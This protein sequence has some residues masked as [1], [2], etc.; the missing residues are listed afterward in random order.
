MKKPK[1]VLLI[2]TIV[3]QL[4]ILL[5]CNR[6]KISPTTKP[7]A[8]E[9]NIAWYQLLGGKFEGISEQSPAI[10]RDYKPWTIQQ[11]I[12]DIIV[13]DTKAFLGINGYGIA[14]VS[15]DKSKY[16]LF[17]YYYDPIIFKYRTITTLL[18]M[19]ESILCHIYFNKTLNSIKADSLKIQGISLVK[20][21]PEYESFK[22]IT[23]PFQRKNPDWES[24]SFLPVEPTRFFF[25]WKYTNS[26]ETRFKYTSL[27]MTSMAE[28]TITRF[29]FL[30]GYNITE[31]GE[32]KDKTLKKLLLYTK[33]QLT[34]AVT[35]HFKL[36]N[37]QGKRNRIYVYTPLEKKEREF[38]LISVE[39]LKIT[40]EK[41]LDKPQYLLLI[42][43]KRYFNNG[44]CI[45]TLKPN[46]RR[47]TEIQ[48][49]EIPKNYSY[50]AFN[51]INNTLL[52]GWE[53]NAFTKIGRAGLLIMKL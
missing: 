40:N 30:S 43:D 20:L 50:N 8:E 10:P 44:P 11:H 1:R 7:K 41:N 48:L 31:I 2:I 47:V 51:I 38:N 27:N 23:I 6:G 18:P 3:L 49:P 29:E 28:Q 14:S 46:S 16:P 36:K 25:E 12:T 34:E 53:E 33:K 45:F 15:L 35:I 39:V 42:P 26:K 13:R 37:P 5:S 22:F 24:V 21:V 19:G 32:C 17:R 9:N 52:I 4:T